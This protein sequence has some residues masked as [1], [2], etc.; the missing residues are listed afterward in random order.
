MTLVAVRL[1]HS[2]LAVVGCHL[3][4][5]AF[6][7]LHLLIEVRVVLV[8]VGI[9]PFLIVLVQVPLELRLKS[10]DSLNLVVVLVVRR[11]ILVATFLLEVGL[12][13]YRIVFGIQRVVHILYRHHNLRVLR[14]DQIF[15]VVLLRL[16]YQILLKKHQSLEFDK[17]TYKKQ[18]ILLLYPRRFLLIVL[19]QICKERLRP[20]LKSLVFPVLPPDLNKVDS[21]QRLKLLKKPLVFVMDLVLQLAVQIGK[22]LKE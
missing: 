8:L 1:I 3:L 7:Y 10:I 20:K 12:G 9:V 11:H 2:V 6:L 14:L 21:R 13:F 18:Q 15:L 22:Y 16:V 5:L 17:E 19:L 4:D